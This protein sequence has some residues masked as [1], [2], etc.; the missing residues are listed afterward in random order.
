MIAKVRW[1]GNWLAV[2]AAALCFFVC[3]R[4]LWRHDWVSA[5]SLVVL[6]IVQVIRNQ[7]ERVL[8]TKIRDMQDWR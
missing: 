6:A 5:G 4:C 2:S 8:L 7:R 3:V 1:S